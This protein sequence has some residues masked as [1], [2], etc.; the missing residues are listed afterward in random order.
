[1]QLG[2]KITYQIIVA[3]LCVNHVKRTDNA[4]EKVS[5]MRYDN[6]ILIYRQIN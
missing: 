2:K 1:M 5:L 4:H 6:E 3:M